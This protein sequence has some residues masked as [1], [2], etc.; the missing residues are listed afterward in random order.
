MRPSASRPVTRNGTDTNADASS[1][2]SWSWHPPRLQAGTILV[3]TYASEMDA[4]KQSI[5][6]IELRPSTRCT[7]SPDTHVAMGRYTSG[8]PRGVVLLDVRKPLRAGRLTGCVCCRRRPRVT[9]FCVLLLFGLLG[10]GG[11]LAW[12]ATDVLAAV[13]CST[14]CVSLKGIALDSLCSNMSSLSLSLNVEWRSRAAVELGSLTARVNHEGSPLLT[15]SLGE[16]LVLP[17]GPIVQS[18]NTT[19]LLVVAEAAFVAP[20]LRRALHGSLSLLTLEAELTAGTSGKGCT[21][22]SRPAPKTT[23]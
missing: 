22:H 20:V 10:Y 2:R 21:D 12:L 13:R 4:G 17:G 1:S 11:Y 18:M 16:P 23:E 15:A 7:D 3:S 6:G 14:D 19:I 5:D 9:S 8:T